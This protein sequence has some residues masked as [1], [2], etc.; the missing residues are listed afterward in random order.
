MENQ[1]IE[2]VE[3]Q[4]RI[5]KPVTEVFEAFLDPSVTKNF[6]FTKSSGKLEA[7]TISWEWGMYNMSTK[8]VIK[9]KYKIFY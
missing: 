3:T 8:A 2:S 6:W 1:T 9:R 4:M 7:E 5:R